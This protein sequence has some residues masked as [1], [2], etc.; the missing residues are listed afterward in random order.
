M[1]IFLTLWIILIFNQD[2]VHSANVLFLSNVPSPSHFMWCKSLL[3][4]LYER[5]HNI[6]ALSPDVEKSKTNFTYFHL[7]EVYPSFYNGSVEADFFKIGKKSP[8]DMYMDFA[9]MNENSCV[10]AFKSKGYQ[11]LM[12]YTNDFKVDLVI[13][14]STVSNCLLGL[15]D[16]FNYPPMVAVTPFSFSGRTAQLSESPVYPAFYPSPWI[17]HTQKLSFKERIMTSFQIVFEIFVDNY[18]VLP[19]INELVHKHHPNIPHVYDIEKNVT[20]LILISTQPVTDYKQPAFSNVKLVGGVQIQKP[21]QL[22]AELVEI[23]DGAKNG[24]VLFSLGTNVRSDTLGNKRITSIIKAFGRLSMYTFL[25]KFETEEILPIELPKNVKIQA[26][27]PQNDVL[28]HENTKLFISHCGL[29]STQEALWYGVPVLGFPVFADQPQNALRLKILG[30]SETLSIYDFTEEELFKTIKNLLEEPKYQKKVKSLSSALRDQPMTPLEEAT[31]WT[32]WILRHPDIDL[33]S[34][35]VDL[36]LFVRHSLDVVFLILMIVGS[37]CYFLIKLF[38]LLNRVCCVT[39]KSSDK[40]K[41][42]Q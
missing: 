17:P 26:W 27:I 7:E 21:K 13:H 1:K 20:K 28:A 6:T 8:V 25:W 12:D 41:K 11:Q 15:L 23:A 18:I 19:K 31:Y 33:A 10:A 38:K 32:E 40:N 37:T 42:Y 14:D 16:K 34:P 22:P 35:S 5:G 4:S 3:T 24:L 29:L 39:K 2:I 9:K 30:V 36:S